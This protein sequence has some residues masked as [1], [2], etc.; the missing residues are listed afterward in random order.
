MCTNR[1]FWHETWGWFFTDEKGF[2]ERTIISRVKAQFFS[3]QFASKSHTDKSWFVIIMLCFVFLIL[4]I[5]LQ[6]L[7]AYITRFTN[8]G[9]GSIHGFPPFW[10]VWK[11]IRLFWVTRRFQE[12]IKIAKESWECVLPDPK[13]RS[14]AVDLLGNILIAFET[15]QLWKSL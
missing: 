5:A 14:T 4:A 6:H 7:R 11:Y 13:F 10:Q 12:A 1:N 3:A 15:M 9:G 2:F 8:P